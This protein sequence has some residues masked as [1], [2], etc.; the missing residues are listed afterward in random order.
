MSPSLGQAQ[1]RGQN[2]HR[3]ETFHT[4]LLFLRDQNM[5]PAI[6]VVRPKAWLYREMS[7]EAAGGA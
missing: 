4:A 5:I 1:T 6:T 3:S 7:G 2:C